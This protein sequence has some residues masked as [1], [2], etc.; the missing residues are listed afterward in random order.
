M[1]KVSYWIKFTLIFLS[2][3]SSAK[4]SCWCMTDNNFWYYPPVCI[5]KSYDSTK[6]PIIA[7]F[8]VHTNIALA[9]RNNTTN[10]YNDLKNIDV[11][12]MMLTYAP[13]IVVSWIDIR[14]TFCPLYPELLD[15]RYI[16]SS[17][18]VL[19]RPQITIQSR[20]KR[21]NA[22]MDPGKLSKF[23]KID[24]RQELKKNTII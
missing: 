7:N 6:A 23:Y 8:S 5:P 17:I 19:W 11:H 9:T 14:L 13:R 24:Q 18:P 21:E 1:I 20:A 12:N 2:I 3:L 10:H 4:G 22:F 15:N 16:I